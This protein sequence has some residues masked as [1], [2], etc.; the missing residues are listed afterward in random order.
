[1]VRLSRTACAELLLMA[2]F[3]PFLVIPR[4]GAPESG[5]KASPRNSE[6]PTA[7]PAGYSGKSAQILP[8]NRAHQE[9]NALFAAEAST[10]SC[11]SSG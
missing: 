11:V 5:A 6:P 2:S 1:M 3:R 4:I 10:A 7:T 9:E 8:P